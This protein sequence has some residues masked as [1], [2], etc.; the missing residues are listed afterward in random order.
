M[1]ANEFSKLSDDD[2]LFYYKVI[3]SN[4]KE[5]MNLHK[6]NT[7]I[8]NTKSIRYNTKYVDF[9]YLIYNSK[10]LKILF[11]IIKKYFNSFITSNYHF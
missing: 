6:D 10:N 7:F 2:F 5:M 3:L 8:W 11:D 4:A 1:T 9:Y